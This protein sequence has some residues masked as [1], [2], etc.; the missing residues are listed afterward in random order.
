[1]TVRIECEDELY[2][3][4]DADHRESLS[5]WPMRISPYTS[6]IDGLFLLNI[7]K[8]EPLVVLRNLFSTHITNNA[9]FP[10][11]LFLSKV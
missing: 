3:V 2:A 5:V 11:T 9:H 8:L 4:L 6:E 10:H 7:P 1:M